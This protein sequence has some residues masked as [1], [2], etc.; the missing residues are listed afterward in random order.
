[1]VVWMSTKFPVEIPAVFGAEIICP[2]SFAAAISAKG[3]S[4]RYLSMAGE[5]GYDGDLCSYMR[6]GLACARMLAG[7]ASGQRNS[8]D[9]GGEE[10]PSM[11]RPDALLC[12]TNICSGMMNWYRNMAGMLNAP[13]FLLDIPLR[14]AEHAAAGEVREE[15]I[16]YLRGQAEEII[17]GLSRISGKAWS[18]ARFQEVAGHVQASTDAWE[19]LLALLTEEPCLFENFELF[20]YMPVMVT[21][22]A[23]PGTAALLRKK[24]EEIRERRKTAVS[25]AEGASGEREKRIYFEGTPCWPHVPFLKKTLDAA[26]MKVVADTI[27]PSLSFRYKDFD[28]ML[29]AYCRTINGSPFEEGVESRRALIKKN[30]AEG[31]LFHVNR[32]CRPWCGTLPQTGKALEN[33]GDIRLCSFEGDQ[34]DGSAFSEARFASSLEGLREMLEEK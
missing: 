3:L 19:E 12:C 27:T 32:S 22:R 20:D 17:S 29:A 21:G 31:A 24:A 26:G 6:I 16:A 13:L 4:G 5:M 25:R 2:E 15:W 23:E 1:M 33:S 8:A 34:A 7:R 9:A 30:R 14:G 28:G 10:L 11:P 18:P